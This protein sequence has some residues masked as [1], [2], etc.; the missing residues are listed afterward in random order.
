[1]QLDLDALI[2]LRK[3]ARYAEQQSGRI[4]RAIQ[5]LQC[6]LPDL[7]TDDIRRAIAEQQN[8][9]LILMN[10]LNSMQIGLNT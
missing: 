8:E 7:S 4:C 9:T 6:A 5:H 10:K 3:Q 2:T 1:M